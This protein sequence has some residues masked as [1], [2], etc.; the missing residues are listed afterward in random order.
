LPWLGL[1]LLTAPSSW[2]RLVRFTSDPRPLLRACVVDPPGA[3]WRY[4]PEV[5]SR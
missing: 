3:K 5:P 1:A 2:P 4:R